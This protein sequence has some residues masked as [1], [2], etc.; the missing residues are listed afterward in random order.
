MNIDQLKIQLNQSGLKDR[1]TQLSMIQQVYDS[2]KQQKILCI[3]A[4]TGT[5]KTLSYL[6]A[7]YHAKKANQKLVISTATIALQEQ[8]AKKDL[9]LFEQIIGKK[10]TCAI[11][12]GRRNYLCLA[13]LYEEDDYPDLF[14]D[15]NYLAEIKKEV[16]KKS[17]NGDREK[18]KT[19][20]KDQAWYPLT[21]DSTGCSNSDCFFFD[22]CF[23]FKA[24]N[25]VHNAEIIVTNHSLLLADLELGGGALLPEPENN[26]YILDECHHL[27]PRAISHFE[28][29]ARLGDFE[30][31]LKQM[32]TGIQRAIGTKLIA[33]S[34]QQQ[35]PPCIQAFGNAIKQL[36]V[37]LNLNDRYFQEAVW[38]ITPDEAAQLEIVREILTHYGELATHLNK[39]NT[40]IELK[41]Q[42]IGDS[43]EKPVIKKFQTQLKFFISTLE[44]FGAT[45]Q[46]FL[47]PQQG[48][49]TPIARWFEKMKNN[50]Y[51]CYCTPISASNQLK[52]LLWDKVTN[53]AI[54]CSATV[55][56]LGS[57]SHFLRKTGL[58]TIAGAHTCVI[59]PI[60]NYPQSL[61]FIPQMEHDPSSNAAQHCNESIALLPQLILPK[62]STLVL[63]TS[64]KA[65]NDT[66][67]Q[68]DTGLIADIL[69]QGQI[70]KSQLIEQ[71]KAKIDSGQRSVIFGLTSFA[72]GVDLPGKYCQHVII[73]KLP[74]AVPTD[75][76][77]LT[78][79][80]WLKQHQMNAFALVT[81]PETSTKLI[82]YAGRLI[83]KEEDS[84]IVTILDRRL[85]TKSYGK[86]L[87]Q[88]LPPFTR[89]V[90]SK[91]DELKQHQFAS[92]FYSK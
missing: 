79:S 89:L 33:S 86:Q 34:W 2:L 57:F 87:L 46:D 35:I 39:I 81:L 12:K 45:W 62:S 26:L 42:E 91:I 80:E 10:V 64:R 75:P 52:D 71:H 36:R 30:S 15:K 69:L 19:T 63:F 78:R 7:A 9:P 58:Q 82:Q 32:N 41:A 49:E 50:D 40:L 16:E 51:T 43:D 38:R 56:S 6:I 23:F 88:S 27:P 73:H 65:M 60:F 66:Y 24:R 25:K 67:Q 18:L 53:G 3:E 13:K 14:T 44:K 37:Q 77:E 1:P 90:S 29:I 61:I 48:K 70:A 84:G 74:F 28:K 59:P 68:L 55:Q 4:P 83:R 92:H 54:L 21:T 17:W 22:R 5:G 76:V 47:K 85:Y 72:E 11:A 20:V 31:H 8:L